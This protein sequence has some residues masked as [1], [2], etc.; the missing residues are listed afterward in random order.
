MN[1]PL[2]KKII[3][4]PDP[5]LRKK[6]API[7]DFNEALS[8]LAHRMIELMHAGN[9]VG[10]AAPQVGICQRLFVVNHT[11][12]PGADRVY[13]NP[14][15]IDLTG[16]VEAEE[17]CLSIP[18]VHVMVKRAKHCLMQ[19]YD[20]EGKLIEFEAEDLEARIWQHEADH[21]DGRLIIDRMSAADQIANKKALGELEAK[22][23]KAAGVATR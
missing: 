6:C 22:Y 5:R 21:L 20:L 2:P 9:G 7:K 1:Q 12:E 16:T 15:L 8:K 18:E 23:R 11:G 17:G 13:I 19:A 4:Y 14:R 3:L 10:L